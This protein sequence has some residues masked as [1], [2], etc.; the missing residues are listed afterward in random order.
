M[1]LPCEHSA[2]RL[3]LAATIEAHRHA[4]VGRCLPI[5][6]TTHPG[7]AAMPKPAHSPLVASVR[8]RPPRRGQAVATTRTGPAG[9]QAGKEA[10]DGIFDRV[11]DASDSQQAVYNHCGSPLVDALLDGCV[12]HMQFLFSFA[13]SPTVSSPHACSTRG[14]AMFRYNACLF[15][16]GQT[17]SGKT[18]SMLGPR[19]GRC[20]AMELDGVIPQVAS[21]VFRRVARLEQESTR[22]GA[23]AASRYQL[24]V[25]YIE[26]Y[27]GRAFDLLATPAHAHTQQGGAPAGTALLH[28]TPPAC[29]R[30]PLRVSSAP[31]PRSVA[32][33]HSHVGGRGAGL[34]ISSS[35]TTTADL[36]LLY[37]LGEQQSVYTTRELLALIARGAKHRATAATGMNDH[38]SRSHALLTLTLEHRWV[39]ATAATSSR[40]SDDGEDTGKGK[41]TGKGGGLP[42]YHSRLSHLTLVDL[43]GSESTNEAHGGRAERSG[44]DVNLGLL[45]LG[46]VCQALLEQA[47]ARER[48]HTTTTTATTTATTAA[49][50]AAT[51]IHIPYRNQLL[52]RLLQPAL[53]GRC[54]TRL[55]A[56]V[57]AERDRG[58][59]TLRTLQFARRA[60]AL[61]TAG[62]ARADTRTDSAAA[63]RARDPMAGDCADP[64]NRWRRRAVWVRTRRH[65]VDVFA[66]AVGDPRDPLVLYVHGSGPR[67]SSLFWNTLVQQLTGALPLSLLCST[68][69]RGGEASPSPSSPSSSTPA[70]SAAECTSGRLATPPALYHVAIDCPGYGRTLGDRQTIR[71][72]P[73][74]FLQDVVQSLGK[75]RAWCLVG[76]SQGACAVMNAALEVTTSGGGARKGMIGGGGGGSGG[77][78]SSGGSGSLAALTQCL[79]VCHP[80]GH[81]VARYARI[82]QPTALV[83]DQDDP[84]HPISVGRRMRRALPHAQWH[85]Y[86]SDTTPEWLME[87][88][89]MARALLQLWRSAVGS[90]GGGRSGGGPQPRYTHVHRMASKYAAGNSV[91]LP[92]LTCVAGGVNAWARAHGR[93]YR[94]W[95]VEVEGV[96][97]CGGGVGGDVVERK[98]GEGKCSEDDAEVE[99]KAGGYLV[100]TRHGQQGSSSEEGVGGDGDGSDDDDAWVAIVESAGTLSWHS[101][102]VA[103]EFVSHASC[104]WVCVDCACSIATRWSCGDHA[105]HLP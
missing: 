35:S 38:S 72:Y 98:H 60:C 41:G 68:Q 27:Q 42:T 49:A 23:V 11:F 21:D 17:G 47:R 89:G 32:H 31:A 50:A 7:V 52:T 65:G 40:A 30:V 54:R 12:C 102:T 59:D 69:T 37:T 58:A 57:N 64:D 75:T 55:L 73:G 104:R 46:Q 9:V 62:G 66:R 95:E 53:E 96:G 85:E 2:Q 48:T 67:N 39:G 5:V 4:V 24:R 51:P 94:S 93:E 29:T 28:T 8:I 81:D 76:C 100:A 71:S 1:M 78:G 74:D 36:P 91:R 105:S 20:R 92:D 26:V 77:G 14:G 22:A 16:Y 45:A 44:C 88:G 13:H 34:G 10:F 18:H 70:S 99:A 83:F 84:G 3:A 86:A 6:G 15:A 101:R 79:A 61:A 90:G 97:E 19:G 87:Q 82:Q 56:C 80:V 25:S 103:A 43:A 33:H 63:V